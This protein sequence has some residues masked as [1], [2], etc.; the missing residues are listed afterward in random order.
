[1]DSGS[2]GDKKLTT[3]LV[4]QDKWSET[5]ESPW[6]C[7]SMCDFAGQSFEDFN[8]HL[9]SEDHTHN[10]CQ[11]HIASK[12]TYPSSFPLSLIRCAFGCLAGFG[13]KWWDV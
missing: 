12:Y 5:G 6:S 3:R 11:D 7:C 4:L 13:W 8:T 2:A 1:M 10:V 9:K